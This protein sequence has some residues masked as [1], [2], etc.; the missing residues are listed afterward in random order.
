MFLSRLSHT[1][2]S[3]YKECGLK[4]LLKYFERLDEEES[5]QSALTFGSYIHKIFERGVNAKTYRE[6]EQ[7]AEEEKKNYKFDDSYLPK[8]GTCIKNFLNFNSSLKLTIGTELNIKIKI[9]EDCELEGVIDRV[10]SSNQGELLIIDYKTGAKEKTKTELY[11]D[12]QLMSYVYSC[13]KHFNIPVNKITASHYYPLTNNFVF[14][15]YPPNQIK[16]F[17][18][19]KKKE[20]WEIRSKTKKDLTPRRNQYCNNCGY[21][22]Y[23]PEMTDPTQAKLRLDEAIQNKKS[24]PDV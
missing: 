19:R 7:I 9:M 5:N 18:S 24:K 6:L 12:E 2:S 10:V 22:K 3:V 8:V 15:K 4:F 14:V 16:N 20:I 13:S 17:E 1:K 23:C 11:V 21:K